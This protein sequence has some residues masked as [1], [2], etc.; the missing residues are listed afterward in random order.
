MDWMLHLLSIS[1][2]NIQT[3]LFVTYNLQGNRWVQHSKVNSLALWLAVYVGWLFPPK[4]TLIRNKAVFQARAYP[5]LPLQPLSLYASTWHAFLEVLEWVV[6]T[7]TSSH[8]LQFARRPPCFSGVMVLESHEH[9]LLDHLKFL[10][11]SIN[12]QKSRLHPL[13]SITILGMNP[14]LLWEH[15]CL[16][17]VY[18]L[19]SAHSPHSD[20]GDWFLWSAFRGCVIDGV[21]EKVF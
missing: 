16:K 10:G 3:F 7:V 6:N 11:L 8:V 18:N 5:R 12:M 4:T 15:T 9:Q 13:Q 21:M 19:Y 17:S 2:V 1:D 14:D 20:W